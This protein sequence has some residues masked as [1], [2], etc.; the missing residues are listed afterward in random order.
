MNL[1]NLRRSQRI[2]VATTEM[3]VVRAN[4]D[5]LIG[6]ARQVSE[7]VVH[8][9]PRRFDVDV[10]GHV[11]RIG[12]SERLRLGGVVDL[13]LHVCKR[14]ACALAPP[15][16]RIILHL[17]QDDPGVFGTADAAEA[18]QEIFLAVAQLSVDQHQC[19]G[20]VVACVDGFGDQLRVAR[21]PG[22][23]GFIGKTGRLVSQS[24]H[25]FVL[26]IDAG[27]VVV[28]EF[29]GR[30]SVSHENNRGRYGIGR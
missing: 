10:D 16:R 30:G 19:L 1:S 4:D 23:A 14:L 28:T 29:V 7:D 5:V 3:I 6:L 11:Q 8:G 24:D 21:E 12:K 20:A 22:I 15:V 9:G 18:R 25:D 17:H 2:V 26:Y 27:I 13:S